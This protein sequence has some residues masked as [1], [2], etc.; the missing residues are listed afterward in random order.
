M[1]NLA[2]AG[3][4]LLK[5]LRECKLEATLP[6][7]AGLQRLLDGLRLTLKTIDAEG[8]EGRGEDGELIALLALCRHLCPCW[9]AELANTDPKVQG[10]DVLSFFCGKT[11]T[12]MSGALPASFLVAAR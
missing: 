4:N 12:G 5:L 6:V 10:G 11:G 7:M 9:R 3:E 8:H 1:E 2:C